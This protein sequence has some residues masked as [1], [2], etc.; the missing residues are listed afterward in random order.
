MPLVKI[1]TIKGRDRKFLLLLI[2][3]VMNSVQSVL[4]LPADDR[5]IRLIEYDQELFVMKEP[6]KYL[7]EITLFSGRTLNTRKAL[8]A[9]IVSTLEEKAGIRKEEV[10]I[11]LNEQPPENWGVRGGTAASDIILDFKV[12]I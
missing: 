11:V 9:N 8:Y 12:E 6:Y 5:N 1:E 3:S 7:I 10:F 4:A 2:D